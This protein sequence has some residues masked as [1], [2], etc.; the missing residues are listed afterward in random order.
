MAAK[1]PTVKKAP[2]Y[3]LTADSYSSRI[4]DPLIQTIDG[5]S[6]IQAKK[7]IKYATVHVG[8]TDTVWQI[9]S[10]TDKSRIYYLGCHATAK[11][12]A[13][14]NILIFD[15]IT[16]T[17][18]VIPDNNILSDS[19]FALFTL[20]LTSFETFAP[21]PILAKKGIRAEAGGAIADHG[22]FT[23]FYLVEEF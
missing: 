8:A 17:A 6:A 22:Y 20:V 4:F 2:S 11:D 21:I 5:Y 23:V 9:A 18:P 1:K 13:L 14:L 3:I 12:P 19:F 10:P 16:G 15:A 7:T